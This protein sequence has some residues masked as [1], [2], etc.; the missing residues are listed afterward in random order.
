M[1]YFLTLFCCLFFATTI[2]SAQQTDKKDDSTYKSPILP[3]QPVVKPKKEDEKKKD[4]VAPTVKKVENNPTGQRMPLLFMKNKLSAMKVGESGFVPV[5]AV[6][7][8]PKRNVWLDP[9]EVFSTK[10]KDRV[11]A[12]KHEES[13]YKLTLDDDLGHQWIGADMSD[14]KNWISVKTIEVKR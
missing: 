7:V 8:D 3:G 5:T 4:E 11:V 1:Y 12:I 13:G 10:S 9:D 6:K 2:T 14:A